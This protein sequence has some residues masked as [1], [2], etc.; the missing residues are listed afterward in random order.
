MV[1]PALCFSDFV[2]VKAMTLP[3]TFEGAAIM[4]LFRENFYDFGA[5]LGYA[6]VRRF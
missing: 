5:K 4:P 1:Y 2:I 3:A 6:G